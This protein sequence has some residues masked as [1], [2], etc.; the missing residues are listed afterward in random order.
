LP[1]LD[2]VGLVFLVA[3]RDEAV[4]FAFELYFF[5]ILDYR[6]Q[7]SAVRR[8][9]YSSKLR[10]VLDAWCGVGWAYAVWSVPLR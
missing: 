8:A 3:G 10:K 9:G 5:F 7:E 1:E 6:C 4:D 2:E